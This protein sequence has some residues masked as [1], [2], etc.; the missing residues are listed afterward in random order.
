MPKPKLTPGTL[1]LLRDE[2][3][4]TR[5]HG[6]YIKIGIVKDDRSTE[7]RIKEHQTGNPRKIINIEDFESPMVENLE[8]RLH[9]WFA[10]HWVHGEWFA[11]DSRFIEETLRPKI[12]AFITSQNKSKQFFEQQEAIKNRE[13]NGESRPATAQ[14]SAVHLKCVDA[15]TRFQVAKAKKDIAKN[16]LLNLIGEYDGIRGIVNLQERKGA[17]RFN[18]AE[19]ESSHPIIFDQFVTLKISQPK[20]SFKLENKKPLSK[21][22]KVLHAEKQGL[23][24]PKFKPDQFKRGPGDPTEVFKRAHLAYIQMLGEASE[25]EFE[26]ES[27]AAKLAT[28]IGDYEAIQGL[29]TWKRVAEETKTFDEEAF[30]NAN[31]KLHEE[32]LKMGNNSITPI[33]L[34]HRPYPL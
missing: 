2:D 17:L 12:E 23:S 8:T 4:R 21:T 7:K 26:Y 28:L 18:K 27:L 9:H 22:H 6:P 15:Y 13:T 16:Q 29:A 31:P 32:F 14:E 5:E 3:F 34:M 1:Y 19:F 33:V 10:E 20:G 11:M 24:K 30:K 25:S